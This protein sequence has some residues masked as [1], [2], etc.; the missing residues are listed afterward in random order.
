MM[1]DLLAANQAYASG[2][3]LA[4]LPARAAKGFALVTCMDTRIEPLTMLGLEPGDAKIMRNAGGRVTEDVL[5]SLILATNLLGVERIAVM[6]HTDCALANRDD[7]DLR[8]RLPEESRQGAEA[9]AFLAMPDPDAALRHD[10]GLVQA[11]PLLPAG[12]HV[13]GWRYHVDTGVVEQVLTP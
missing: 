10:V 1:E 12:V 9:W 2:F 8:S 13:E 5:R 4:G 6:Q 11:C 3:T 7:A